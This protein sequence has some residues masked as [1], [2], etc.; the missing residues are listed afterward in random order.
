MRDLGK[1]WR[2]VTLVAFLLT[3]L[4]PAVRADLVSRSYVFKPGVILETGITT[5]FGLRLDSVYFDLPVKT[6][7]RLTLTDYPV[8]AVIAVSNTT[9]AALKVALAVALFDDEGRLLAVAS[10]GSKLGWIKPGRQR[11]FT[12]IFD[13]VFSEAFRATTFQISA[14]PK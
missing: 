5:D 2:A 8:N 7:G 9:D 11:S 6:S 3:S 4:A 14:E 1:S 13:G 10:G 12:L